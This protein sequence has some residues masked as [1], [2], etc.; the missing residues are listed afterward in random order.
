MSCNT[1][2]CRYAIAIDQASYSISSHILVSFIMKFI[3][4]IKVVSW[5]V[6]HL[7]NDFLGMS[8]GNNIRESL[9]STDQI[10]LDSNVIL[11]LEEDDGSGNEQ[12]SRQ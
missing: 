10:L 11:D 1:Q 8:L 2:L 9:I 6:K 4:Q 7:G 12:G 5:S 3:Y